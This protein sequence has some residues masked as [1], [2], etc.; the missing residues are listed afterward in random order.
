MH[1]TEDV[2]RLPSGSASPIISARQRVEE[3]QHPREE[4]A[5]DLQYKSH[6]VLCTICLIHRTSS[7][8][9]K[10]QREVAHNG[11]KHD[12]KRYFKVLAI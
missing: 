6:S 10:E 7:N 3:G 4:R 1:R 11:G 5:H 9:D 2:A 8:Q 12:E